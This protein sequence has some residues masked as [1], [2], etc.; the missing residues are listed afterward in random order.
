M[1]GLNLAPR[2]ALLCVALAAALDACAPAMQVGPA[3]PPSPL[4]LG[5]A[6]AEGAADAPL[7]LVEFSDFQCP[8]CAKVQPTL[9]ELLALYPGRIR[10]VFK[11]NPLAM[12]KEARSAALAGLAAARQGRWGPMRDALFANHRALKTDDLMRYAEAAGLDM[13]R[14][15]TDVSDP[16]LAAHLDGD[17]A[18]A[19][20]LGATG[21]PTFFVNGR[22]LSGSQPLEA[23]KELVDDELRRADALIAHGMPTAQVSA[24]LTWLEQEGA[25]PTPA[26]QP[27]Q[28]ARVEPDTLAVRFTAEHPWRGAADPLVTMVIFLDYQCP[29]CARL[30]RTTDE[31]LKTYDGT[32]RVVIRHL[33]LAFHKDAH[34]A[35][36]AA[37]AA[38][39]QGRYWD[40]HAR[41]LTDTRA[42]ARADL[43]R[44]GRELGLDTV[45]LAAALSDGRFASFVSRD[46]KEAEG[47][48]VRATPTAVINGRVVRGAKPAGDFAKIIDEELARARGVSEQEGLKGEALYE[49]LLER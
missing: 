16:L 18:L 22:K 33:P 30:D 26:P 27:K 10:H 5:D 42:L 14:F 46:V 25:P 29:Y 4:P 23:F 19:A 41:L 47:L 39:E 28:A 45:R 6:P 12:H 9:R 11:N 3:P 1:R 20:K 37:M 32:L 31:L 40:Y 48:G 38:G 2:V 24:A 13:A 35:A 49:R 44:V 15:R 8:F 17:M 7:T 43:I 21:T 34:L 36:Q